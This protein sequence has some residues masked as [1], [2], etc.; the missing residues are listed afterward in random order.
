MYVLIINI[1]NDLSTD[2][3]FSDPRNLLLDSSNEIQGHQ[4]MLDP[5]HIVHILLN[6]NNPLDWI[7]GVLS[8]TEEFINAITNLIRVISS[9]K[10]KKFNKNGSQ[11]DHNSNLRL[12][13]E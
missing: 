9:L 5:N 8:T 7:L 13:S 4:I 2:L 11:N 6:S 12:P 10:G 1:F 3:D